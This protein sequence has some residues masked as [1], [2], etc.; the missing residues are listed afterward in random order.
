MSAG[1]RRCR[2]TARGVYRSHGVLSNVANA[3]TRVIASAYNDAWTEQILESI[4]GGIDRNAS[5]RSQSSAILD[6]QELG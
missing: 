3:G 1:T 5:N 6:I 4:R 2:L